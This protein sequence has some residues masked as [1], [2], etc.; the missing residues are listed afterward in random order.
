[1]FRLRTDRD[2][3]ATFK[4]QYLDLLE[5]GDWNYYKSNKEKH[6]YLKKNI[7]HA[8]FWPPTVNNIL[9][10]TE[11]QTKNICEIYKVVCTNRKFT[12]YFK[13]F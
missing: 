12:F 1:M 13:V 9:E 4:E 5:N 7:G 8:L 10:Y 11:E 3:A 6:L 2:E